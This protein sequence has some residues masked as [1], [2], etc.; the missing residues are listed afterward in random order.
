M[1]NLFY[2]A[3]YLNILLI[4]KIKCV[5]SRQ[6]NEHRF[7]SCS[8]CEFNCHLKNSTKHS[9]YSPFN[10]M[11]CVCEKQRFDKSFYRSSADSFPGVVHVGHQLNMSVVHS[12]KYLGMLNCSRLIMQS[13]LLGKCLHLLV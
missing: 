5:Q 2:K 7:I 1:E 10:P 9:S 8:N 4:L 13:P 11:L 6:V 3:M 12:E